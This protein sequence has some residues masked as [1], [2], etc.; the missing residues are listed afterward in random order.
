MT[1]TLAIIKQAHR[2][3]NLIPITGELTEPQVVEGLQKLNTLV[4]SVFGHEVGEELIDNM[5][6]ED[7][8]VRPN[9]RLLINTDAPVTVVLPQWPDSGARFQVVDLKHVDVVEG[10]PPPPSGRTIT[11][12]GNGRRIGGAGTLVI[13]E[14]NANVTYM[15][16][17][18]I[19]G[20]VLL[21]PLSEDD[22]L[23]FPVQYD[24]VFETSLAM[25]LNPRYGRS[26]DEQTTKVLERSLE[27]LKFDYRQTEQF[28]NR[29]RAMLVR[30]LRLAGLVPPNAQPRVPQLADAARYLNRAVAS[31]YG[32]E[33]GEGLF[34]WP[35]GTANASDQR[36]NWSVSDWSR[37]PENARLLVTTYMNEDI[38]LVQLPRHG[39]RI[40]LI[41]LS[42]AD[43]RISIHGNGS[44]IEGA[45]QLDI[46]TPGANITW[47][48]RADLG[49]WVRLGPI[50]E[51]D[52]PPFPEHFDNYF[53]IAAAIL[54]NPTM[55]DEK[56]IA[57]QQRSLAMLRAQ[58]RQSY[59]AVLDPALNRLS[60]TIGSTRAR[61]GGRFGWMN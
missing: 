4:A 43:R 53:E 26:M 2:E 28:E 50:T 7:S 10:E 22:D 20:W 60:S 25:R 24:A 48:F 31:L 44:L 23:P 45:D 54:M 21:G 5:I 59:D 40:Q 38:Y 52:E 1:K 33:V 41:D 8:L 61:R 47:M 35:V 37:P 27:Q 19:G 18:D 46:T 42:G 9:E 49:D 51:Y 32:Y 30:S 39:A 6:T 12:D 56:M 29:V 34:D 15:Y 17:A 16:R 11:V 57:A 13:T 58:Y 14:A 3:S 36:S 55:L